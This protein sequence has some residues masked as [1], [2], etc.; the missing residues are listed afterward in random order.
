LGFRALDLALAALTVFFLAKALQYLL[1]DQEI[2]PAP[3]VNFPATA[4]VVAGPKIKSFGEYA[5]LRSSKLFGALS[6]ANVAAKTVVEEDLPETTLDLELLG[7]V[8][9]G[10]LEP[11]YAIIRDKKKRSEDT[12]TVGDFI[13]ADAKVEEIR[14]SE[15]VILRAGKRETLSMVFSGTG[16]SPAAALGRGPARSSRPPF[17]TSTRASRGSDEAIRVVNENLRYINKTRFM[18]EARQSMASLID[19]VRTSPN[20]VDSR[21]SGIKVDAM[22]TDQIS[23]RAGIRSG[24]IIKSVNGVR[25]NS[26]DDILAQSDRFENAPEIRVVIERNGRHRTLVYKIR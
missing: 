14:D 25:V 21:P 26:I 20:T 19:Q 18:E 17:P 13:V 4:S 24:D 22:G 16:P 2:K 6:S 11:G 9:S 5:H 10:V 12:Y 23:A 7:C 15:V 3:L 1:A 8:A